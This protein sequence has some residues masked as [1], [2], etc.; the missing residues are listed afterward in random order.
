MINFKNFF[1][2]LIIILIFLLGMN[3]N[4]EPVAA[5]D[6][7]YDL[8]MVSITT[9][10]S[11]PALNQSAQIIVKVKY[12]GNVSL[13]DS[14]GLN[15]FS[16]QFSDF[17]LSS[18][19]LPQ[20]TPS[21]PVVT[22]TVLEYKFNG[23]F[24]D[25][26]ESALSFIV[27]S[28]NS[29]PE[30][31]T[32]NNDLR[33]KINVVSAE[34]LKV[35]SITVAPSIPIAGQKCTVTATVKNNGQIDLFSNIGLQDLEESFEDFVETKRTIPVVSLSESLKIGGTIKYIFEGSFTTAGS[36]TLS[37]ITNKDNRLEESNVANNTLSKAITVTS[38]DKLDISVSSIQFS[39]NSEELL[40]GDE[41][42]LIVK[43]TNKSDFS[44]TSEAGLLE[45]DFRYSSGG[46][47]NFIF[48][49]FEI[50]SVGHDDYPTPEKPLSPGSSF[51][52]TFSG[53]VKEAGTGFVYFKID[54]HNDLVEI[55]EDNNEMSAPYA[56]YL[57]QS[58]I[59][60]FDIL[61]TSVS[62]IS[63]SSVI[64]SWETDKETDGSLWYK[65]KDY[66]A[67]DRF[68]LTTGLSSW[69]SSLNSKN[70]QV[71]LTN[72][73][74]GEEYRYIVKA[75]KNTITKESS[76]LPFLSPTDD[77]L[78]F[79]KEAS[80]VKGEANQVTLKWS[81]GLM[82]NSYVYYKKDGAAEY[83]KAGTENLSMDHEVLLS[84]LSEAK[85]YFY[86]SSKTS[87]GAKL[88]SEIKSFNLGEEA[89][90]EPDSQMTTSSNSTTGQSS[91]N[92]S[93]T[94]NVNERVVKNK[95][96]YNTLRGKI[97]LTVE[98]NGEA[99]YVNP[100]S[101]TVH[102]LGRPKDAFRVM[103]EQGVGITNGDL[104][105]IPVGVAGNGADTDSD[106]L[107][108]NLEDALGLNASSV[109][110][111]GDGFNDKNELEGGY[112]PWGAGKQN[113]DDNFRNSQK[114]RILLQVEKKGEAWYVNPND[115]KRYFLGRPE[116]AFNVMR[117]LGLGISDDNFNELN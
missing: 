102:Y 109:D 94:D 33:V 29:L 107:P 47:Y 26:G 74:P 4:P 70:H 79:T 6:A 44:L 59:D 51:S 80:Y 67:F 87:L 58:E 111:D 17:D 60:N 46:D 7:Y 25:L 89:A 73:K 63:S 90:Q 82:S 65:Q 66:E 100:K 88:D 77:Q 96:L 24:N 38:S 12:S 103:R 21:S 9:S 57:N 91:S 1:I 97:I 92:L 52:Y 53:K 45:R 98:Q 72:L 115:G 68:L 93:S 35:E 69:P 71:T 23:I 32:S 113:F 106:G 86:T 62:P 99:Y 18:Q 43:V 28:N 31:K 85:Y 81:T 15:S 5:T 39:D 54:T 11:S 10:P 8:E 84:N 36:R 117:N 27:N 61:K 112:N 48:D 108:D 3:Y 16:Y 2:N 55:D 95:T 14:T 56:I 116:D 40:I 34:D 22:G 83:V 20:P 42:S 110:T 50:K 64:V 49:G 105:K 75:S 37:F 30:S 76:L 104:Y 41:I 13:T 78:K 114:G 19:V 101:E